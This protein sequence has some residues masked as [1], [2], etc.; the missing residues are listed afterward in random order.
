[1]DSA[2]E[3]DKVLRNTEDHVLVFRAQGASK[4]LLEFCEI[5]ADPKVLA[6]K[7]AKE[8]ALGRSNN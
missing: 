5:S 6:G 8:R 4:E 3:K 2:S 7:L 1:L